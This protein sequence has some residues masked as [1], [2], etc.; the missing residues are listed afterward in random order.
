MSGRVMSRRP[1]LRALAV[2]PLLCGPVGRATARAADQSARP[3]RLRPWPALDRALASV[4]ADSDG[5]LG[6]AVVHLATRRRASHNGSRRFAMASVYKL[7]IAMA[8]LDQQDRGRIKRDEELDRWLDV[9]M[10]RSDNPATD[11]ILDKLGGPPAVM[12]YLRARRLDGIRVDRPTRELRTT[13]VPPG[14][15]PP[16]GDLRDTCTPLGMAALLTA[17]A[18]GRVLTADTRARLLQSMSGEGVVGAKRLPGLLPPG[19]HVAHKTGTN[20]QRATNDVGL[21]R[22]PGAGGELVVA[23]FLAD[24]RRTD[25]EKEQLIA[26]VGRVAYDEAL[27]ADAQAKTE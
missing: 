6:V 1:L 21:V 9:M 7:P 19:T 2:G 27:R 25:A 8:L 3:A 22:L 10:R 18:E 12:A 20:P 11:L 5:V 17:V 23:V 24:S 15:P 26:R 4:A 13:P 14:A 16:D